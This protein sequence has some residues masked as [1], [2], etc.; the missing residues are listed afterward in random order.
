MSQEQLASIAG[1][2]FPEY[3]LD[4]VQQLEHGKSFNNRIYFLDLVPLGDDKTARL[5]VVLKA[6]GHYFGAWK[7]Q[8]EVGALLLLKQHCPSVPT[9]KLLAWSDD[10]KTI[11]CVGDHKVEV[12]TAQAA[13]LQSPHGWIL[14]SRLTGRILQPSDPDGPHGPALLGQLAHHVFNWRTSLPKVNSMGNIRPDSHARDTLPVDLE[15]RRFE[16][17]GLIL[18][19]KYDAAAYLSWTEHYK[20]VLKD[21]YEHL[22]TAIELKA[23]AERIADPVSTFLPMISRLPFL[24]HNNNISF[25]HMD[26]SPRNILVSETSLHADGLLVITVIID[27]EFAALSQST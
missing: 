22:V 20:S 17:G 18:N 5:E 12:S 15:G 4:K 3:C 8:N 1:V 7:I 2:G 25:T 9:P 19:N 26:L 6:C 13:S 10:G 14:I 27:W 11:E 24:T 23:L 21:K 16:I